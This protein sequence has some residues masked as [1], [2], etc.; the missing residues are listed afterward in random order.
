MDQN[1]LQERLKEMGIHPLPTGTLRRW[2]VEGLIERPVRESRPHKRGRFAEWPE[3]SLEDAVASWMVRYSDPVWGPPSKDHLLGIK[4]AA[5]ELQNTPEKH[6][7][8]GTLRIPEDP[9][10]CIFEVQWHSRYIHSGDGTDKYVWITPHPLVSKWLAGVERVRRKTP[11][12]DPVVVVYDWIIDGPRDATGELC[13][14]T[15]FV[16][17]FEGI[18]FDTAHLRAKRKQWEP[19]GYPW[20]QEKVHILLRVPEFKQNPLELI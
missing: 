18:A 19:E 9:P 3:K 11:I 8:V 17:S 13:D 5:E 15:E 7:K 4:S 12:L 2:A 14:S 10:V 16:Y 1:E 6:V 20:V